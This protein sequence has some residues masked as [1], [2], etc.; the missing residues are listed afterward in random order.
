[1]TKDEL[2]RKIIEVRRERRVTLGVAARR[3]DSGEEIQYEAEGEYPTADVIK[4]PILIALYRK[5]LEGKLSLD[6][7]VTPKPEHYMTG[8]GVLND[9]GRDISLSLRDTAKLMIVVSDN[10]AT[11]LIID[12]VGRAYVNEAMQDYG[13]RDTAVRQRGSFV[14]LLSDIR[15]CRQRRTPSLQRDAFKARAVIESSA[16]NC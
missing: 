5:A 7:Q 6:E 10:V 15:I 8:T 12:L 14:R 16:Q 9:L 3:L 11:N 4:L 2:L 13:L 1:M